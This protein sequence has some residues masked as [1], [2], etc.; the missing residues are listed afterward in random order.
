TTHATGTLIRRSES[1][2]ESTELQALDDRSQYFQHVRVPDF[3]A[4]HVSQGSSSGP[5]SISR[6]PLDPR[7]PS[8]ATVRWRNLRLTPASSAARV[9]LPPVFFSIACT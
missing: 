7:R 6:S 9:R 4:H 5:S 1:T 3:P 8:L 2:I